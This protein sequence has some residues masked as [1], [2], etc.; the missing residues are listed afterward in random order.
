MMNQQKVDALKKEYPQ[1]TRV[2]LISMA[3]EPQ[4]PSGIQGS[5]FFVDDI[6]QIHVEWDNGSTLALVPGEDSYHKLPD[7][8]QEQFPQMNL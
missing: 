3:G 6:G 7:Q 8:E 5:V 4:M 2:E 1:G